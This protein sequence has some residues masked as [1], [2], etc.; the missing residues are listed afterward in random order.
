MAVKLSS[1]ATITAT[2]HMLHPVD[3]SN[4]PARQVP[5]I[6]QETEA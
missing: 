5:Q 4:Y 2:G 6:H 3:R 1:D